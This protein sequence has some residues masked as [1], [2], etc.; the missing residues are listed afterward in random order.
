MNYIKHVAASVEWLPLYDINFWEWLCGFPLVKIRLNHFDSL[1]HPR[2][3]FKAVLITLK[4]SL[5]PRAFSCR[6]CVSVT[7]S[8][9]KWF[10]FVPLPESINN[11]AAASKGDS[12]HAPMSAKSANNIINEFTFLIFAMREA[13]ARIERERKFQFSCFTFCL[14]ARCHEEWWKHF[15]GCSCFGGGAKR[16]LRY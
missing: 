16:M 6:H 12:E 15:F 8:D 10:R 9:Y 13:L 7:V 5:P 11:G 4:F 2:L 1:R 14:L 3:P